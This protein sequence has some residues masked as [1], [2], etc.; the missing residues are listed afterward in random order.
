MRKGLRRFLR[1]RPEP[2][3]QQAKRPGWIV[4]KA[5]QFEILGADHAVPHQRVEVDDLFPVLRAVENNRDRASQLLRLLQRK[6][7]RHFVERAEASGKD[8]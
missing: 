4:R 2:L 1:L 3:L 8:Y 6:H 5:E 7:L